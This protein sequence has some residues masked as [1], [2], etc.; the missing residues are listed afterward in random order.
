MRIGRAF[1]EQ[2]QYQAAVISYDKVI[3]LKPDYSKAHFHR[4]LALKELGR[5]DQCVMSYVNVH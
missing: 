1:Y 3:S 4:A 5:F 2:E